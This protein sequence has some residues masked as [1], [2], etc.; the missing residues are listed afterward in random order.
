VEAAATAQATAAEERRS[1]N[2][3]KSFERQQMAEQT[4]QMA[5]MNWRSNV[6]SRGMKVASTT[7]MPVHG[8][9]PKPAG[10][11]SGISEEL[12][13]QQ[14]SGSPVRPDLNRK[15]SQGT[16]SQAELQASLWDQSS[17][18][19]S[20]KIIP[21]DKKIKSYENSLITIDRGMQ[22]GSISKSGGEIQKEILQ[23]ELNS[24]KEKMAGLEM[25]KRSLENSA[26]KADLEKTENTNKSNSEE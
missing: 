1:A 2:E 19:V 5:E 22:D 11:E 9:S 6:E 10:Y 8:P 14:S 15:N 20:D 17:Q 4:K 25:E 16:I 18:L 3:G 13:A 12:R 21:L 26:A 24:S 23:L 7:N